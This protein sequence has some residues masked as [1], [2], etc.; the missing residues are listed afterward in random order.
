[1]GREGE[2]GT[3]RHEN[4]RR[5]GGAILA[6]LV[7]FGLALLGLGTDARGDAA[8][9]PRTAVDESPAVAFDG[10]NYFVAWTA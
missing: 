2:P 4:V 1:M 3:D 9:T 10:A 8:A 7:L 6:V 5:R